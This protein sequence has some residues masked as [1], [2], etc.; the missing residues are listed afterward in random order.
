MPCIST[1]SPRWVDP[2]VR[3]A[4]G[5]SPQARS[6]QELPRYKDLSSGWISAGVAVPQTHSNIIRWIDPRARG[7]TSSNLATLRST[8][9]VS[10]RVRSERVCDVGTC[11]GPAGRCISA[12]GEARETGGVRPPWVSFCAWRPLTAPVARKI[13][14]SGSSG[15]GWGRLLH[16]RGW[17]MTWRGVGYERRLASWRCSALFRVGPWWFVVVWGRMVDLHMLVELSVEGAASGTDW[18]V[19][20]RYSASGFVRH[21]TAPVG[22][23]SRREKRL[24]LTGSNDRAWTSA[25]L[26]S[27]ASWAWLMVDLR[28]SFRPSPAGGLWSWCP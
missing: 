15:A 13:A 19:F 6:E 1:S 8:E 18:D 12:V 16:Q 24:Q 26:F 10:P 27:L 2:R 21:V 23:W 9:G 20:H 3:G 5:G 14:A 17:V 7:V 4:N 11:F 28:A 25:C 22:V